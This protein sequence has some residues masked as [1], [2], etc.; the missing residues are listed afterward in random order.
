MFPEL[1]LYKQGT[2]MGI[3]KM[4]GHISK[5]WLRCGR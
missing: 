4:T 2:T 3:P 1:P 5:D